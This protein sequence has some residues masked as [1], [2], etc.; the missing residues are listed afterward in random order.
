MSQLS[1][2]RN[3]TGQVE[4]GPGTPA[5][6]DRVLAHLSA[7][8]DRAWVIE[9][10]Q[11][12]SGVR[13]LEQCHQLSEELRR[14]R[15]GPGSCVAISCSSRG[16]AIA[17]MLASW[18][19]GACYL[20][21]VAS[22]PTTRAGKILQAA[23][24]AAVLADGDDPRGPARCTLRPDGTDR[25]DP[26]AAY[27]IFTSGSTGDP[28]GV[29]LGHEGLDLLT[30]W[31]QSLTQLGPGE[32]AS[33][34]ADLTFDA[35][36]WEIW[37]A[38]AS[39]AGLVVP[40]LD[41][42][43]EPAELQ[44]FLIEN[45]IRAGFVPTGLVPDLL[46]L[47]WPSQVPLRVLFTGGDRLSRR[48]SG[49]YPFRLINAYGPTEC[50]VVATCHPLEAADASTAPPIGRPLPHVQAS[51]VGLERRPVG[52]REQGELWLAGPALALGYLGSGTDEAFVE[53]SFGERELPQRWYRTGDL[54]S[55]D[56]DGVLHYL[57]RID[58]QIQIGGRRTEPAEIVQ[59]ILELP[60]VTGAVVFTRSTPSG[61]V[62][63]AAAVTPA[64][65][66]PAEFQRRLEQSLPLFMVPSQI[67]S[68]AEFPLTRNGKVDLDALRRSAG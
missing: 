62:R 7:A 16:P 67:L 20:P 31:H 18:S 24:P 28:K 55:Q 29:V 25:L 50:T 58:D 38:L 68:M 40:G 46:E 8:P 17:S 1:I 37:G 30:S 44:R 11:R 56:A 14:A 5:V 35:S 13:L 54:V 27:L 57:C 21:L 61:A 49:G 15:I 60:G 2:D 6:L 34:V 53:A 63:L 9:D 26:R 51:V 48:P 39:G 66:R 19:V 33:Q 12:F 10:G 64:A 42:L 3:A 52:D 65:A 45:E 4:G 59:A 32:Y 22:M 47:A 23:R 41:D 43:L 36:V